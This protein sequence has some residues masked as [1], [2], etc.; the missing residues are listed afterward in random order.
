MT[1]SADLSYR[2]KHN[3][4]PI[5]GSGPLGG[6]ED[7]YITPGHTHECHPDFVATPIG[8]I[9]YG[10]LVCQ[11]KKTSQ[12]LPPE[13]VHRQSTQRHTTREGW[14][15]NSIY[16]QSYDLYDDTPGAHPQRTQ[17]GGQPRHLYDRRP[18][19]QA[20][21]QGADYYRD[22][23]KYRGIGVERLDTRVGDF[24]HQEHK[25]YHST[26]PPRYDITHAVQPYGLWKR[27]QLRHGHFNP[28]QMQQ[29]ELQHTF[30]T[31]AST[32]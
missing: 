17:L 10:F 25:Y 22:P 24:G 28:V 32:F 31:K 18:P 29:F 16:T 23:L 15:S 14:G 30:V 6:W 26:P 21:L 12:G 13:M 11:R 19:N 27:E 20:Q 9:P 4:I 5:D 1:S 2:L 3:P 8:D 7:T